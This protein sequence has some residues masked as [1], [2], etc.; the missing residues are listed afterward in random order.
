MARRRN[1]LFITADQWRGDCLSAL[2]HR[3]VRTPTLDALAGEGV[4]FAQHFANTSPCSPSRATL[5]TG[6]YLHNHRVTVNGTP[7]DARHTNWALEMRKAGLEP[8]LVGY[9]DQTPDPRGLDPLDPRLRTYEGL[10]PGL[11]PFAQ[12][13]MENPGDWATALKSR[14]YQLPDDLRLLVWMREGGPDYEDGNPHPKPFAIAAEDNDTAWC[15]DRAIDFI[16]ERKGEDFVLHLSLL[17]PHPPFIASEPWNRF[18]DPAHV[19]APVRR[20]SL[21]EEG[22]QHPFLAWLLSNPIQRASS[23]ERKLRRQKAIYFSLMAEVDHHLGRL[24]A[25]LRQQGLFEDTLIVFTS[26]HGEMMGDHWLLGKSGYF[27]QAY[28]V[29]LIIKSPEPASCRGARVTVF[30]EHVDVMPTLLAHLGLTVPAAC[31]GRALQPLIETGA[32]P[33]HWRDAAHFEFDWRDVTDD[34]A[35]HMLGLSFEACNLSVR[36]SATHKLVHFAGLRPLLFDL[37]RDPVEMEDLSR[38]PDSQAL[39]LRE[40]QALLSWRMRTDDRTLTHMK[41]TDEGIRARTED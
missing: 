22:D 24:F 16:S 7:L 15:V 5:H 3:C 14:G 9:T 38:H 19:P 17:R 31:D 41:A 4:L 12:M 23:N 28:H 2:G 25:F 34:S 39:L 6:L 1:I 27:D 18:I 40:T 37:T 8:A 36:R 32:A 10:L 30:S 21:D 33:A 26:D 13:G 29:P 11:S 35:E 20:A